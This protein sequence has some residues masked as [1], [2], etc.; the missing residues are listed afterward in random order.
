MTRPALAL[1]VSIFLLL[2]CFN[3]DVLG[4][5]GSGI[6][7]AAKATEPTGPRVQ[8][9]QNPSDQGSELLIG[10][11]IVID[12]VNHGSEAEKAGLQVGD[13]LLS[14]SR[15]DNRGEIQSPFD[16]MV[17]DTEQRLLGKVKLEGQRDGKMLSWT[18]G[19]GAWG[20]QARPNF[21]SR[22]LSAYAEGQELSKTS[23]TEDIAKASQR[24]KELAS[25]ISNTR[26]F[27]LP[28]WLFYRAAKL[29]VD[30]KEW[31]EA[32]N[33]FQVAVQTASKA[34]PDLESQ[35]LLR[36]ATTYFWRGD[37][38]NN[39]KYL[40]QS[41]AKNERPEGNQPTIAVALGG[42][43]E[44]AYDQGDL[45]RAEPYLQQ[46]LDMWEKLSPENLWAA[47]ML[48]ELG[49]VMRMKGDLAKAS[50]Y[51]L[52]ALNITE[53]LLPETLALSGKRG[54]TILPSSSGNLCETRPPGFRYGRKPERPGKSCVSPGRSGEGGKLL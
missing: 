51:D 24:W 10:P 9:Q 20:L 5:V 13:I 30:A 34:G 40:Q 18:L 50:E 19:Y 2:L 52:R 35:L 4:Q 44:S 27:W 53:K 21:S 48:D 38:K 47:N 16:L 37:W 14:W 11:G 1:P 3:C 32:D 31:S 6:E 49:V 41:I 15:G 12:K 28:A 22:L 33:T 26:P 36:W 29:L 25:Q 54:G 46:S 45:V 7:P 8:T 42:L 43:G 17:I 39:E 23:K